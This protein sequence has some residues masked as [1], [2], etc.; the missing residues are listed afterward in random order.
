MRLGEAIHSQ[1]A[2]SFIGISAVYLGADLLI[3][4]HL[5]TGIALTLIGAFWSAAWVM[6][7]RRLR[8]QNLDL[9]ALI[10]FWLLLVICGGT[11]AFLVQKY[12]DEQN[13]RLSLPS[14]LLVPADGKTPVP[15]C[16]A[17]F[18]CL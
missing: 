7:L 17:P 12:Y 6:T 14:G 5:V 13:Y 16:P 18:R 11:S 15:W 9:T 3:D 8:L 1:N 4:H 2:L 10:R